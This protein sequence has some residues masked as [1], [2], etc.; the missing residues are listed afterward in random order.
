MYAVHVVYTCGVAGGRVSGGSSNSRRASD[1]RRE[2]RNFIRGARMTKPGANNTC[3]MKAL[4][5]HMYTPTY[6]K[7]PRHIYTRTNAPPPHR[8]HRRGPAS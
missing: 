1:E 3:F 2:L 5:A 4:S 8:H 6:N 7:L